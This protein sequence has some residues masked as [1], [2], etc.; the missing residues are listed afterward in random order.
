MERNLKKHFVEA[1]NKL[2]VEKE[3]FH[4]FYKKIHRNIVWFL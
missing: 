1:S 4:E 2:K 3:D